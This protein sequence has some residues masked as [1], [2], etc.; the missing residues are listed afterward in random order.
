VSYLRPGGRPPGDTLS[1][2]IGP[3][4]VATHVLSLAL[5]AW[6]FA[7]FFR[8]RAPTRPLFAGLWVVEAVVAVQVVAL[9]VR[10][11]GGGEPHRGVHVTL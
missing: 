2:V 7:E 5:A 9:V 8:H 1:A 10:L 11:A 3:L 4:A 6:A